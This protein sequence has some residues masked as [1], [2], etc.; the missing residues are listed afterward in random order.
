MTSNQ[1]EDDVGDAPAHAGHDR[2]KYVRIP[3]D[4]ARPR[5]SYSIRLD[6][7][8]DGVSLGTTD[9]TGM[10][11]GHRP[12][13]RASRRHRPSR[14]GIDAALVGDAAEAAIV[15]AVSRR[16]PLVATFSDPA[17]N[18]LGVRQLGPR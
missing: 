9:A 18:V 15:H 6:R 10:I 12:R 13:N 17:G 4:V 7:R 14:A 3:L 2:R 11:L 5:D 1:H 8:G 16:R